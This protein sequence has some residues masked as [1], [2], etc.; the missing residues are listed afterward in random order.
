MNIRTLIAALMMTGATAAFAQTPAPATRPPGQ[1]EAPNAQKRIDAREAE[2]QK[3][4]DQG[5]ASGSLTDKEAARLQKG[6]ARVQKMEDKANADGKITKKEAAHIENAQNR[7]SR[8]I[9]RE[10]H[11]RQTDRNHDGKN[12]RQG[13]K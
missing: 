2:Q 11:D 12:D 8:K 13:K 9:A 10:K 3:R 6:Q 5:K 4:I 1:Q 7:E